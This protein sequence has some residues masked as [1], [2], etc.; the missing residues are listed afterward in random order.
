MNTLYP[1]RGLYAI[2]DATL[3]A[4]PKLGNAAAL[5][6]RGGT[7]LLQYRDKSKEAVRRQ[8]EAEAL[9][10][11]CRQHQV[12][13]I[14]NDDILLA[15]KIGADGVHL[16]RDDPPLAAAR[17]FLGTEAIIGISCYNQLERAIAAEQAGA[18]YVAFGRCFP[19]TTKPEAV[20]ASL[21][22]LREVKNR[23]SLPIVAIGG[24]TPE[25]AP[26]VINAGASAIA[27]IGGLFKHH[28]IQATATAYKRLFLPQ[29]RPPF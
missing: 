18:D 16:G 17:E 1:V 12:P 4:S 22:L 23:L 7:S 26:Q 14:I 2:A 13:L 19:S 21:D 20:H 29:V 28:D 8:R 9:L 27:V 10:Q 3:L 11:L 5:A 15:A 6:L 25:N 24:I